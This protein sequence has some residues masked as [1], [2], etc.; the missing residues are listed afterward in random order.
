MITPPQ[1]EP[2]QLSFCKCLVGGRGNMLGEMFHGG[3]R[4]GSEAGKLV[5]SSAQGGG[6]LENPT[7]NQATQAQFLQPSSGG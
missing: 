4:C 6:G 5:L 2:V 7:T 1:T 3:G